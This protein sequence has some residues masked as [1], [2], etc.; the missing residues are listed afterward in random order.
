MVTLF[1]D[2]DTDITPVQAKKYGY[3]LI[4]MPYSAKGETVF[5]YEDFETFDA[6]GFYQML[7]SGVLPSTSAISSEKY[8]EYFC[9]TYYVER[10]EFVPYVEKILTSSNNILYRL[11]RKALYDIK[12][13]KSLSSLLCF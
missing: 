4:S 11:L 6:H 3:K 5:P 12:N 2:T 10:E 8:I 7:R 13:D 9:S 1:T